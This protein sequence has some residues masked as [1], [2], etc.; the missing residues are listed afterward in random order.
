M[1]IYGSSRVEKKKKKKKKEK[2]GY[3]VFLPWPI[4]FLCNNCMLMIKR[5]KA[6]VNDTKRTSWSRAVIEQARAKTPL[7]SFLS[8]LYF[9]QIS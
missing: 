6:T 7:N 4:A 8:S 3:R 9:N 5:E 1:L 2:L